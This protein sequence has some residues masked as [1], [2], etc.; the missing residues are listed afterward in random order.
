MTVSHDG[1]VD[2]GGRSLYAA[3]RGGGPIVVLNSGG[4][5]E[6]VG[7]WTPIESELAR[8]ATVVTYDRAGLG[9]SDSS[10]T[11]PTASDIVEDLRALLRALH[12]DRPALLV[13]WSLSA[14]M[15]QLFACNYSSEVSGLLLLDPTPDVAF[16]G[17]ER[18]PPPVQ[19]RIREAM[20]RNAAH[21]G[22]SES[23]LY[24]LRYLP[25]SCAELQSALSRHVPA[26]D[27]PVI[28]VTATKP[29]EMEAAKT[30]MDF[31]KVDLTEQHKSI[32][33]RY[34]RGQHVLAEKSSHGSIVSNEPD[35]VLGAIRTL[36]RSA[37]R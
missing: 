22:M 15:A 35:L 29:P 19:E 25:E 14:L 26:L 28:V 27:T 18:H 31:T 36:L 17:F 10:P 6:G 13:G 12:L 32:V 20:L 1:L 21:L 30:K 8:I 5:R 33:Q 16:A 24:E 34:S 7:A 4:G 3:V 37:S 2:I 9:R 23:G 11:P